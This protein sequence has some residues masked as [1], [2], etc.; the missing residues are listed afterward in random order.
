M[1]RALIIIILLAAA[2]LPCS[3]QQMPLKP[4][5]EV[6]ADLK[7]SVTDTGKANQLLNLALCYVYKQGEYTND[8]DTAI[9]IC[10][11]AEKI[12]QR[13]NDKKIEA[14]LYFVYS[15]ALREG[16]KDEAGKAYIEKSIA[17][18]K[19]LSE[20]AELAEAWFELSRYYSAFDEQLSKKKE[21]YEKA[22]ALFRA[23]GNKER[24][25]QVLER[26]GDL[27]Q[28][29]GNDMQ[30][31]KEL[32]EALSI[33]QSIGSKDLE[34]VY[35]LFGTVSS[36][37]GDYPGAVKYGLLTVKAAEDMKDSSAQLCSVYSRLAVAYSNWSKNEEAVIYLRKALD[38]AKKNNY[39][40]G[41]Q[42]VSL[43]L[44]YRFVDLQNW[45]ESLRYARFIDSALE[46]PCR[47]YDSMFVDLCYGYSYLA[48]KQYSKAGEYSSELVALSEKHPDLAQILLGGHRYL[49]LYYM[50][51][52]QYAEAK[53]YASMYLSGAQSKNVKKYIALGYLL[54]SRADSA[55]GNYQGSLSSYQAYKNLTDS[56]LNAST[57][58]QFSQMQVE[59]ETEKKDN[60]IKLLKQQ[61]EIHKSQLD[62][63][64]LTNSIVIASIIALALVLALLYS[65]YRIKQ[66]SN[67]QL[68]TKQK[69]INEKNTTLEKLVN[70]KDELIADKDVLLKEKDWLVKEIHHRVKNNLQM[71]ISLLN[72]QSEFLNHPSA[73]H[74]IQESRERMQAIA[75]IHQKLYQVD[76]N[77]KIAMRSYINELVE[78]IRNSIADSERFN[79]KVQVAD[80]DLDISQTVPL[81]LIM[82]EAIT[83]AI[84]YAYRPN[85][86]G[87]INISL[88]RTGR[89]QFQLRIADHGKGLPAGIDTDHS[90]SLG[91][92][93]IRLFS[94]QL[95][96]DLFFRNNRGLEIILNF[97]STEYSN[98]VTN[99]A[100]AT[101]V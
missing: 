22:L 85:Q 75:I 96:G 38:V 54:Q 26:I 66:R 93:L 11:E 7:K 64:R 39:M 37:M 13:L 95:E 25:A 9:S 33:Y 67:K 63:T 60:D 56:M 72:A 28:I 6:R 84:K 101:T 81:G 23:T 59:Y 61:D 12:I 35:N 2:L 49:F 62:K 40:A 87:D 70:E 68:E 41:L 19:T 24:Q 10:K 5:D 3:A 47:A 94:E 74:A 57:N 42:T 98:I 100:R 46:K 53:K 71:I 8:L 76:N 51:M 1:A 86:K 65:R 77:S 15:N 82:N 91:L 78:S 69:E 73:V 17:L 32:R 36:D 58:F 16:K 83:N 80:I 50:A 45:K 55:L 92:Q 18:Y 90:N 43:Q 34:G 4:I 44:V 52:H 48:G 79:F 31:M 88:Q 89:E 27:D 29:M 99:N 20:P 97:K 30:A 21:C 14:R